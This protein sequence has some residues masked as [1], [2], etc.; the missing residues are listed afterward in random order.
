MRIQPP[1]SW[2]KAGFMKI[3]QQLTVIYNSCILN[4]VQTV[5]INRY[6][7]ETIAEAFRRWAILDQDEILA[8]YTGHPVQIYL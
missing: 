3:V 6:E 1:C 2:M 5:R 8:I 7:N 4:H